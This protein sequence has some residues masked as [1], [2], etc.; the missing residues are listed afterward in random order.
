MN[1]ENATPQIRNARTAKKF[2]AS[3]MK[4]LF[5]D[6]NL[7]CR[8]SS[9]DIVRVIRNAISLNEYIETYV[10]NST[11]VR[12]PSGDTVF[13]RIKAMGS[14]SGSHQ[15]K[16]SIP[17][18]NTSSH[19]GI[20]ASTDLIDLT[21]RIAIA[22]GSF[23]NPVNVAIDEHDEPYYGMDNRYLINAPFHKFRG[24]ERAYR[25]ATADSVKNGE[26]FTLSVMRKDP[27]DGIDN[28]MEV[29]LLLGHA[30][31]LGVTINIV[32]MDR[33]YLDVGVMRK[34][35][36]LNLKYIIPAKDNPKV[37]RFKGMEMKYCDSGFSFLVIKD[38]VSSGVESIEMKFVHVIYYTDRKRHD[39]SFYT[40][41]EVTESNVMELAE[42]YRER[43]GVENGYLEK[44]EAKEKT[45]SP[46]MGVRYFLFFISVLLYNLWILLNLLRRIA[47]DKWITLMDFMIAMSRGRWHSIMN[48][49]G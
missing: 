35:E 48:D 27:L 38:N 25:F 49:Y 36:A 10:R 24:T 41:M 13:R 42:T 11:S 31:S 2:F 15:R 16:G 6:G 12:T 46:N 26:R 21:V 47:G 17:H 29:D 22:N 30:M 9:G 18:P 32:L 28:A 43:W 1:K 8:Y 39:F 5:P 44:K 20:D 45:H 3:S 7:Q 14:E 23:R 19:R 33:G 4:S 34:V 40:N 37:M